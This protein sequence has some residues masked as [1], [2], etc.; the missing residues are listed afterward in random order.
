[1]RG[2]KIIQEELG[3]LRSFASQMAK[4][5]PEEELF[6]ALVVNWFKG[7]NY[8]TRKV[9]GIEKADGLTRQA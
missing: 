2:R 1:M 4:V 6:E 7:L 9:F 5:Y 3:S 8:E